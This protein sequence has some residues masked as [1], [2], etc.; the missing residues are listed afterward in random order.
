[1]DISDNIAAYLKDRD[2]ELRYASFDYCFNYFKTFHDYSKVYE[3]A[4]QKNLQMSCLQLGFYL[5]SWGMF[6]GSAFLLR[7]SVKHFESLVKEI[8][9]MDNLLW[10]IDVDSYTDTNIDLIVDSKLRIRNKLGNSIENASDTLISKIMLGVFG[11]VPAFDD[12]FSKGFGINKSLT[13]DNLQLL[14]GFYMDYRGEID[15]HNIRTIDF[16]TGNET[17]RF[18]TI[19]KVID[20]VGFT[21]GMKTK[22]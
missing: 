14:K 5:A 21:E 8:A 15:S 6:R 22:R 18:Y 9:V 11:N 20:M 7:K 2:P 13:K 17:D 4:S 12:Y 10:E 1:M 16:Y 19:A 3:I